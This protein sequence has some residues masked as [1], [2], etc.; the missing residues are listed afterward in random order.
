[1]EQ[2]LKEELCCP[3]CT[4]LFKSPLRLPCGHSYCQNCLRAMVKKPPARHPTGLS[5][6]WHE[7]DDDEEVILNCPECRREFVLDDRGVDRFQSDFKL[8]KLVDLYRKLD[9]IP[10]TD[11][12]PEEDINTNKSE[13]TGSKM[14]ED[15]EPSCNLQVDCRATSVSTET[16]EVLSN[17]PTALCSETLLK[18]V[19]TDMPP[20]VHEPSALDH[21]SLSNPDSGTFTNC[22]SASTEVVP[23]FHDNHFA[24]IGNRE[25]RPNEKCLSLEARVPHGAKARSSPQRLDSDATRPLV[26]QSGHYD[27]FTS[28]AS[29]ANY[30]SPNF[31]RSNPNLTQDLLSR[32]D[33]TKGRIHASKSAGNL[34]QGQNPGL[35]RYMRSHSDVAS[36]STTT[37]RSPSATTGLSS[38]SPSRQSSP[39]QGSQSPKFGSGNYDNVMDSATVSQILASGSD[40]MAT[41]ASCS[42]TMATAAS[43]TDTMATA[44]SGTDTMATAASSAAS[45]ATNT[46]TNRVPYKR[47][48]S[49]QSLSSSNSR[50]SKSANEQY[51]NLR[52]QSNASKGSVSLGCSSKQTNSSSEDS[53]HKESEA[54]DNEM[55]MTS[56]VQVTRRRRK[57]KRNK[58]ASFFSALLF[59]DSSSSD[60][61]SLSDSEEERK[62]QLNRQKQRQKSLFYSSSSS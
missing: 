17:V 12:E 47:I 43:G 40:A 51:D 28:S 26:P 15:A 8:S 33:L 5:R 14:A 18:Q 23:Q 53:K 4:D 10:L 9:M 39:R 45:G 59:S 19:N 62:R 52:K 42:N 20:D 21:R 61:F 29:R 60:D 41:A 13:K 3:I 34:S 31:L 49:S 58:V 25:S 37:H 54:S 11:S 6:W 36:S 1:M 44:A 57:K 38:Q 46:S 16:C 55:R 35:D 22:A 27:N 2:E 30:A 50:S 48:G 32:P 56:S 24:E 7:D